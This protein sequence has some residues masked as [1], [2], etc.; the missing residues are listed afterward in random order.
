VNQRFGARGGRPCLQPVPL[1]HHI[2]GR[3]RYGSCSAT[4]VNT[5]RARF[6]WPLTAC[7][8]SIATMPRRA[9]RAG[10]RCDT[11]DSETSA[12]MPSART[13]SSPCGAHP[14]HDAPMATAHNARSMRRRMTSGRALTPGRSA[15][16]QERLSRQIHRRTLCRGDLSESPERPP[17]GGSGARQDPRRVGRRP[18]AARTTRPPAPRRQMPGQGGLRMQR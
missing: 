18:A 4:H 2:T 13:R 14:V 11:S 17:V 3:D 16:V 5:A 1:L 6:R 10:R 9:R 12:S 8:R 15:N 7:A